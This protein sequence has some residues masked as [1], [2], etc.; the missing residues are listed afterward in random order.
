M[1]NFEFVKPSSIADAA[2]AMGRDGALALS[3]GQTLIPTMKQRLAAP[4][5]LVS[6]TGIGSIVPLILTEMVSAAA[7]VPCSAAAKP[8]PPPASLRIIPL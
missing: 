2:K 6:L 3:G 4:A 7:R 5:V 1:H 8:V